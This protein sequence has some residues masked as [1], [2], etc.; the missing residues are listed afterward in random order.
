MSSITLLSRTNGEKILMS[1]RTEAAT[2]LR[3]L[4]SDLVS[5]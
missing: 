2:E 1:K 5:L 4:A 3:T